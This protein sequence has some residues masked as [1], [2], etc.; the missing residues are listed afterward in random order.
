MRTTSQAPG[1]RVY[2]HHAP[3]QSPPRRVLGHPHFTKG[4]TEAPQV[5]LAAA[6]FIS[7]AGSGITR[8]SGL[9]CL[10]L[11]LWEMR[12]APV[13]TSQGVLMRIKGAGVRGGLGRCL[14]PPTVY[15]DDTGQALPL[16]SLCW[17]HL[18][19]ALTSFSL[20]QGLRPSGPWGLGGGGFR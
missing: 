1:E 15:W 4:H 12:I 6:A 20:C 17:R 19:S 3:P 10:E 16:R 9:P 5:T 18:S 14:S 7:S 8:V 2:L 13:L 11:L